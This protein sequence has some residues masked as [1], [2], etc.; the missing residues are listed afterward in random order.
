MLQLLQISSALIFHDEPG[1]V[2]NILEKESWI[3]QLYL[4]MKGI[5]RHFCL[6]TSLFDICDMI[7]QFKGMNL[8]TERLCSSVKVTADNCILHPLFQPLTNKKEHFNPNMSHLFCTIC[9]LLFPVVLLH[10]QGCITLALYSEPFAPLSPNSYPDWGSLV[11]QWGSSQSVVCCWS[12]FFNL[13]KWRR[14]IIGHNWQE[15]KK[16]TEANMARRRR[17]GKMISTVSPQFKYV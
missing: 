8:S 13:C 17:S 10:C 16:G 5:F 1:K 15:S 2:E 6:Y 9:F 14:K 12:L 4:T 11:R 3:R 7:C